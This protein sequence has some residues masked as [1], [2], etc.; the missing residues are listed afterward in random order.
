MCEIAARLGKHVSYLE[1]PGIV[2]DFAAWRFRKFNLD[3]T[4]IEADP[5]VIAV[6][7]RFDII[8]T[9][10]VIEHLP[11]QMQ[12]EATETIACAVDDGGLL[13]FIVDLSGPTEK[14]PMHFHVDIDDLHA[15]LAASG[16]QRDPSSGGYCSI[17][18][19]D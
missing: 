18:R 12:I 6:P 13:I 7:G 19:R 9:D 16:L 2:F 3:I 10:A 1:L 11:P 8:Y 15:R 17:W 14:E 4:M 5:N